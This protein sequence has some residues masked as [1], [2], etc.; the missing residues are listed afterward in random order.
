MADDADETPKTHSRMKHAASFGAG[1]STG[2][3][4]GGAAAKLLGPHEGDLPL[5]T[6]DWIIEHG[7]TGFA[8]VMMAVFAWVAWREIGKRERDASRYAVKVEGLVREQIPLVKKVTRVLTINTEVIRGHAITLEELNEAVHDA[9]DTP[10][11][12]LLPSRT[13]T[14]P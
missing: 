14:P 7:V 12:T 11:S 13:P 1:V 2:V 8:L 4:G 6:F 10:E 5:K 9:D 3:L